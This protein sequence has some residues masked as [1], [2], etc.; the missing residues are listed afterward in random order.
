M[1]CYPKHSRRV[2]RYPQ[3]PSGYIN[4]NKWEPP[5][6][7]VK[8][9]FGF[10][11]VLAEDNENGQLQCH[12]CGKWFPQLSTHITGGHKMKNCNEYK[13]RFGLFQGTA[14]KCKRLRLIQSK[15]IR[16]LQKAGLMGIGNNLGKSPFKHGKAN[17]Y[18]A[19]RKGWKK[20]VEGA[21][22]YGRC[23]LQI[24]HKIIALSKKMKGKTPSLCDIKAEYGGGI[25]SVMHSRYGSY[26]EYCRKYLKLKPLPSMSNPT[27]KSDWKK[28][29]L[30]EGRI[31]LKK[32]VRPVVSEILPYPRN[33]YI[34]KFFKNFAD[35]KKQLLA[36]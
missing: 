33:R 18:A 13:T 21:N 10:L 35:Y 11:G 15:T 4:I 14:L 22:Q 2:L 12:I 19:N 16:R 27:S 23:D 30:E 25:V 20:P 6:M 5:F 24:M 8:K 3:A 29:L 36:Q 9:G 1:P 28:T 34:Y 26:V 32:G 31:A 7:P 17:K